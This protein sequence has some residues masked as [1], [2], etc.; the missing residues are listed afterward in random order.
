LLMYLTGFMDAVKLER[1]DV[2]GLSMG[3]QG[4]LARA[5]EYPER[6]D[7][8]VVVDSAGLGKEFPLLFKLA[9]VPL[10]GRLVTRPNRWGQ[11][12]YFKT[13]EVV[14]SR[15]EDAVAYRQYAYDVTLTE[16]HSKAMR[17]SLSAITGLGGQKSIFTD[18][19]L[20]SITAPTLAI[21]G[22]NDPLFPVEHGYRLAELVPNARMFVIENAMHVPLLDRADEVNELFDG[23]LTDR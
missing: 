19:E 12:N 15:F 2:V 3:A 6:V 10:F 4:A 20:R 5:I 22:E 7:R 16:G 23:F 17:T 8:V 18:D 1:A 14:N 21:W 11:D 13:M 9:N